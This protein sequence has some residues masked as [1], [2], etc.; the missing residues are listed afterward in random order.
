MTKKVLN[1]KPTHV[2]KFISITD[3]IQ[4]LWILNKIEVIK[5]LGFDIRNKNVYKL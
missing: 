2:I 1:K 5:N 3:I 4:K